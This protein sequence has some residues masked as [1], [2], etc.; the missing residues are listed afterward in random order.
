MAEKL[1][2]NE[3]AGTEI[4]FSDDDDQ[5]PHYNP[6]QAHKGT[7]VDGWRARKRAD[8]SIDVQKK[9]A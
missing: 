6:K 1:L 3:P 7:H 9:W 8:G 4:F 2:K 5:T